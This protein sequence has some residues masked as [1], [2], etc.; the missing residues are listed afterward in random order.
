M[1]ERI[2]KYRLSLTFLCHEKQTLR[3]GPESA[4]FLFSDGPN[5]I[6]QSPARTHKTHCV[7]PGS[8][9]G[10]QT[11]LHI[12][13]HNILNTGSQFGL[14]KNLWAKW[15]IMLNMSSGNFIFN[16]DFLH[17]HTRKKQG[18]KKD[19]QGECKNCSS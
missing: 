5:I 10:S 19:Q 16:D 17:T 3:G 11:E 7:H 13:K 8:L 18:R 15:E 14:T 9:C 6:S 12:C 4:L 2:R 1:L